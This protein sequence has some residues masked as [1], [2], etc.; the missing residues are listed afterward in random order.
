MNNNNEETTIVDEEQGIQLLKE[1]EEKIDA[2]ERTRYPAQHA[3]LQIESQE[4][5]R[6]SD[7]NCS[8]FE[9]YVQ[10]KGYDKSYISRL[11]RAVR[12]CNELQVPLHL[13]PCESALRPL[14]KTCYTQSEK[15]QIYR[16]AGQFVRDRHALSGGMDGDGDSEEE[17]DKD[18][19]VAIG[20]SSGG[21]GGGVS[22]AAEKIPTAVIDVKP[23]AQDI[24][25]AISNF[26]STEEV[27]LSALEK[28]V[29][30]DTKLETVFH[31]F[32]DEITSPEILLSVLNDF[33]NQSSRAIDE[34]DQQAVQIVAK[35]ICDTFYAQIDEII[36]GG[37]EDSDADEFQEDE[38]DEE[39]EN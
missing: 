28:R 18:R 8:S 24:R 11:T 30:L 3:W 13:M 33:V 36:N 32:A 15:E 17:M 16:A 31:Q 22:K 34:D 26:T 7:K 20:N 19:E 39:N 25:D 4:L 10:K 2:H 1:C 12:F 14:M 6:Y 27:I 21:C 38:D 5:W 23:T 9:D 29:D 35:K 37:P